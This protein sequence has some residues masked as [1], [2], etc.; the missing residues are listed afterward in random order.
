MPKI[1]DIVGHVCVETAGKKR[2]CARIPGEHSIAK[3]QPCLVIKGGPYDAEKS[4]CHICAQAILSS[5]EKRLVD[6]HQS[7]IV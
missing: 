2:K 5:A 1:R 4:Y 7:L 6:F 3:G